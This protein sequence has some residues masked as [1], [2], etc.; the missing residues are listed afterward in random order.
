MVKIVSKKDEK[1]LTITKADLLTEIEERQKKCTG[2]V[3]VSHEATKK[4][5][6]IIF[7]VIGDFLEDDAKVNI[8]KF[9]I[10]EVGKL[11]A[12]KGFN[13]LTREPLDIP[14]KNKVKFKSSIVL[15]EKINS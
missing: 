14:S 12:R 13:P 15:K 10:F 2:T 9:G 1:K 4:T 5:F 8:S 6:D 11:N 3:Y 7:D